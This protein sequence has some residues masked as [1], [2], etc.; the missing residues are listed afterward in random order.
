MRR[1][2]PDSPRPSAKADDDRLLEQEASASRPTRRD[3]V[4][5]ELCVGALGLILGVAGQLL[6]GSAMLYLGA[7]FAAIGFGML[8][9]RA[10]TSERR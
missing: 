5:Y 6:H 8:W 7:T 4:K 1:T 10:L 2:E 9:F 3:P